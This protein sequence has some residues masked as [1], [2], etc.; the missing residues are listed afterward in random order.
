MT[1]DPTRVTYAPDEPVVLHVT[2]VPPGAR[3]E[4]T[5]VVGAVR[6][7]E[8]SGARIELA[9]LP[10]GGY[11]VDL[12][13]PD[14]TL[15]ASSAFDVLTD[16]LQ[17]PRYGF[18]A[19]YG[20]GTDVA[21][22]ASNARRLHLNAIQLYDWAYSYTRLVGPDEE[23]SDMLGNRVSMAVVRSMLTAFR[24][25][26]ARSFGYAALYGVPAA[27]WDTWA[28]VGLYRSS[29]EPYGFGDDF[30]NV[31][32]PGAPRWRRTI[33]DAIAAAFDQ[34]GFDGFHLDQYGWPKR[35]LRADGSTTDL[36]LTLPA[37]VDEIAAAVPGARLIFNNVNGFPLERSAHCRQDALYTEV[38]PPRVD[39]RDLADL[40]AQSRGLSR[41]PVVVAA[42]LSVFHEVGGLPARDAA[43]LT[44]ATLFSSGATHLLAGEDG[45]VLV[46]PYYVHSDEADEPTAALLERWYTFLVRHGD[47]LVDPDVA[48]VTG[49]Y[50]GVYNADVVV[51]APAGV[52]I[53][54]HPD[55]GAV[56]LR[57]MRT[58]HGLAIHLVNLVGQDE[59]GWD[60]PKRPIA[61]L[62]GLVLRMRQVTAEP[63][64][65]RWLDPDVPGSGSVLPARADG[66]DQVTELPALDA[67]AVVHVPDAAG[68]A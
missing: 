12:V 40:V 47:L 59:T 62:A 60:T 15:V 61:P 63:S 64:P 19:H 28:D 27:E 24:E 25:L 2:D 4:V 30:L 31:V 51:E 48:D 42:Y 50:A 29:G 7:V 55:A 3:L 26:G 45:R 57:I 11:G 8:V 5:G 21:A 9:P 49:A 32:D 6:S 66:L 68:I 1:L 13:G 56:W 20:P 23:Y 38:W 16:P 67:W 53:S 37:L 22:I 35:A 36:A 41:L 52:R 14:G 43:R 34:V 65:V 10:V 46:H 39:L 44:M 54:T 58:P 18:V 17:R 33:V